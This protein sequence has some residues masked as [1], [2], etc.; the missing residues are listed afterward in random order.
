LFENEH[1]CFDYNDTFYDDST[2]SYAAQNHFIRERID[3]VK[4]PVTHFTVD[5]TNSDSSCHF[6][7]EYSHAKCL[8][9]RS[10]SF[11]SSDII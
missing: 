2:F 4:T 1:P 6:Y 7:M 5:V 11:P 10:F 9:M 3:G 8:Q